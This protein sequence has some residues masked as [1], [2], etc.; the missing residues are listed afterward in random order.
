MQRNRLL[1]SATTENPTVVDITKQ[2]N[3]MRGSIT[4]SLQRNKVGLS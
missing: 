4:Q 2:I 1:E 3:A